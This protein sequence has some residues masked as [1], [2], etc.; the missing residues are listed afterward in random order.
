VRNL[1]YFDLELRLPRDHSSERLTL[2]KPLGTI[3]IGPQAARRYNVIIYAAR[4]NVRGSL[5]K[6]DG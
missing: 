3:E 6:I 2:T 5:K 1:G 4:R